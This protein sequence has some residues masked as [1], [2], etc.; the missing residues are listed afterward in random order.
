MSSSATAAAAA[1]T[2]CVVFFS[3]LSSFFFYTRKQQKWVE[4]RKSRREDWSFRPHSS[5]LRRCGEIGWWWCLSSVGLGAG[6]YANELSPC[7][8]AALHHARMH[9]RLIKPQPSRIVT[10]DHRRLR[11]RT[12][13]QITM[14]HTIFLFVSICHSV[15][16]SFHCPCSLREDPVGS[17]SRS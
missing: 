13:A 14:I 8:T 1:T 10:T 7:Y 11:R 5:L 16:L 12:P 17:G 2:R 6:E 3:F 9:A 4:L 15:S